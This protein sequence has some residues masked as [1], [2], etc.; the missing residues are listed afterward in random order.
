MVLATAVGAVSYCP[1]RCVCDDEK[2]HVTCGE[3]ELDVLPIAL[4]P[5]IGRLVIKFNR[6]KSIDSSIQFYTELTMLDLSY[7]HLLSIPER[8]FMYQ[9]KLLQ[10]HLNNNKLGA[11]TNR[12]FGGLDEL[13]VLNLR[14]NFIDEIGSELFKA[15]PKL[16]ELNLG[17]NRIATLHAFLI[18]SMTSMCAS[19]F[20]CMWSVYALIAE[21]DFNALYITRVSV[22]CFVLLSFIRFPLLRWCTRRNQFFSRLKVFHVPRIPGKG[23]TTDDH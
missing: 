9:K 22:C 7:N 20:M 10:L 15:L 5:S 2:L 21:M 17:Q 11:V 4:N 1:N 3:G 8:I 13:R 16:E 6:I 23:A 14:G 18:H 19:F 12:T